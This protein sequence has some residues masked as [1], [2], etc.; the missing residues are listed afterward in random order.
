MKIETAPQNVT[1]CGNFESSEFAIGDLAFI[2][3]MFADK[4]YTY[5]ERAV[6]RELSCN[7]HDSHIMAGTTEIP[8]DVHLPTSLEPFFSMRDYGTGLDDNEVRSIFAGIGIST[9]RDSNEV[10][11]CFGIG[12]LSPYSLCDSFTVKSYKNGVCRNYLCHRDE[13]RKPVV[14]LLSMSD[15]DEPNGL[16]VSLS[17]E[18][19]VYEF[20]KEAVHVF[21]F[22]DGT[23]PNI[24]N[25]SVVSQCENQRKKYI[26]EGEDFG[27]SGGWG[28]MYAIM[29]NIAYKIPNELDEF[30]CDGFIKFDLGELE[31]DTARENLSMTDKV[32]QALKS[33]FDSIKATL[34]DKLIK[35]IENQPT[36][37]LQAKRAIELTNGSLGRLSKFKINDYLLPNTTECFTHYKANYRGTTEHYTTKT[38]PIGNEVEYYLAKPKMV[39]RI[40]QYTKDTR[41]N[42]VVLTDKQVQECMLD[43]DVLR[44]LEDLPKV[45]YNRSGYQGS[46]VKTFEFKYSNSWRSSSS[47]HWKETEINLESDEIV[48][49]E[50]NRWNIQSGTYRICGSART[51]NSSLETMKECGI[52][53]PKVV[54]LKS[55]FLKSKAFKDA[56]FINFEDYV[57][58][59]FSKI[60]PR[61]YYPYNT[62]QMNK[63]CKIAEHIEHKDVIDIVNFVDSVDTNDTIMSV[64]QNIGIKHDA[65]EDSFIQDCL[66]A[67]F[68]KYEMLTLVDSY[69]IKSNKDKI[70]RYLN[71]K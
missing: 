1:V 11:G 69:E 4:V 61:S 39:G 2:V 10:I 41:V 64:C 12:S 8:F 23:L 46:T 55:A 27:L 6:I 9:K 16:E 7:A 47:E 3:D 21:R 53:V 20:E 30:N 5:K 48:Y 29:G 45:V 13:E 44:D 68:N 59:E 33:K 57:R 22:W 19:R 14:T 37:F 51:L 35:D 42:V 15:T 63:I 26:F 52:A 65:E 38:L 67:F 60:V 54:G 62:S 70:E 28:D 25:K 24:N 34:A 49:V 17:V 56:N 43:R 58:R 36:P 31:F 71:E 50:I 18:G 40:K 66:D 32:R